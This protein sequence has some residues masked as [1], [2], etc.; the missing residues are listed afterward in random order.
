MLSQYEL[1]FCFHVCNN[2]CSRL[3]S[4][5]SLLAQVQFHAKYPLID[6]QS[7]RE[8]GFSYA[9]LTKISGSKSYHVRLPDLVYVQCRTS[10]RSISL[11]NRIELTVEAVSGRQRRCL[12]RCRF[13]AKSLK[14]AF[15]CQSSLVYSC[16]HAIVFENSRLIFI[17]FVYYFVS[18]A[19]FVPHRYLSISF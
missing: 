11:N 1:H 7:D 12:F 18:T 8:F 3:T 10:E 15:L 17:L 19:W 9:I 6:N 14:V 4:S 5:I 2:F 16:A 13:I